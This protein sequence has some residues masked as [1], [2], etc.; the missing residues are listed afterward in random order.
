MQARKVDVD[1][2]GDVMDMDM[3]INMD[4]AGANVAELGMPSS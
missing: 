4:A 2:N 1:M 3:S